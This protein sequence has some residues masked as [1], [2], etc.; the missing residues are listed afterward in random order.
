MDYVP[1]KGHIIWITFNPQAGHEQKGR[2]PAFV[3]SPAD[4]NN[5][6]G[7]AIM[8]PIT[9]IIKGYPFEVIIPDS[10]PVKGVILSDQIKNLDWKIRN[11]HYCCESDQ[12]ILK[13]VLDR[14]EALLF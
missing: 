4:Y 2:R 5:K 13:E 14:I 11:A 1:D 9:S 8:C 7:L 10:L 3:I 6:T 12:E